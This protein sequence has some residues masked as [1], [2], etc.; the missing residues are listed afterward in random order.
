[1]NLNSFYSSFD[2]F[3][4]ET[5]VALVVSHVTIALW[6]FAIGYRYRHNLEL[7]A[8]AKLSREKYDIEKRNE[9]LERENGELSKISDSLEQKN[10]ELL[11]ENS[12]LT[13]LLRERDTIRHI[14]TRQW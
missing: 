11:K 3:S 4:V 7:S 2:C 14:R 6:S 10:S 9:S 12:N 13:F 1:M 8:E 5:A